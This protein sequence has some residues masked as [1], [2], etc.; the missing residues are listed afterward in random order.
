MTSSEFARLKCSIKPSSSYDE[1]FSRPHIL[2]AYI[3]IYWKRWICYCMSRP[4]E[5]APPSKRHVLTAMRNQVLVE[6]YCRNGEGQHWPG[7]LDQGHVD[8]GTAKVSAVKSRG[9]CCW[10]DKPLLL[11]A[12]LFS[13]FSGKSNS[14]WS[15][16]I[17]AVVIY[18]DGQSIAFFV[19]RH[20]HSTVS[21][22]VV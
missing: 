5:K 6:A 21:Y 8:P 22:R 2:P 10:E 16:S 7:P 14:C 20:H 15:N 19:V 13:S 9:C 17:D 12:E 18:P 11:L 4:G 3:C 1:L